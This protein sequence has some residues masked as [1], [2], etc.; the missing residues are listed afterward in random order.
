MKPAET[1]LII[2][3][4]APIPGRAK[5]RLIPALGEKGAATLQQCLLENTLVTVSSLQ[6]CRLELWCTPDT[7]HPSFRRLD[8]KYPLS[9]Y[10][11]QGNDLGERMAHAMQRA[12]RE[13]R[14]AIIIGTDC[15]ELTGDD[16]TQAAATLQQGYDAVIGP[17]V[18]GGYYLLGLKRYEPSLFQNI[19]WGTDSVFRQT[20]ERLARAGMAYQTLK[21]K[22]DLDRPADLERFPELYF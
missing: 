15:P 20:L 6:T 1:T 5:T 10:Q 17:A 4:R 12:L 22:H 18:D 14:N 16:I 13:S 3:A 21:T 8:N 9:L 11:Q 19:R 2:F 7:S